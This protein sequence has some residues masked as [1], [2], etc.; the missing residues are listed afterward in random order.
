[1]EA[2]QC[3]ASDSDSSE[4]EIDH[5]ETLKKARFTKVSD[6]KVLDVAAIDATCGLPGPRPP[7]GDA[8]WLPPPPPD[9]LN[10]SNSSH[11]LQSTEAHSG[12]IRSFPH[13]EGNYS[14]HVYI[15]VP[16]STTAKR[17]LEPL[18]KRAFSIASELKPLEIE[19]LSHPPSAHTIPELK[20]AKEY[21]L[22]LSR[23]VPIRVH[24]I[25]SI[26][27]MLQHKF[28]C[29]KGFWLDLDQW[30]VFVNDE[31]TRSFLSLEVLGKGLSEICRQ[32]RIVDEVF[33]LHNLPMYYE[34]PR[35]HVSVA[36]APGN[37]TP[38][39]RKAVEEL[40]KHKN[41][42]EG[43]QH[44]PLWSHLLSKIECKIGN[45]TYCIWKQK[46]QPKAPL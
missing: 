22:S 35:P 33:K 10:A 13:V 27:A 45:R 8:S 1:M 17:Q 9:L 21:H 5:A 44:I 3:Y 18:M 32:I 34:T 11:L 6:E 7:S 40:A 46:V 24:Q 25:N 43:A 28:E 38:S 15:P 42:G 19:L 14:L 26:V 23:T 36:W 12:R 30:E 20:L 4:Q 16:L 41:R 31:Q 29:Q 37:S 2:L 39:L